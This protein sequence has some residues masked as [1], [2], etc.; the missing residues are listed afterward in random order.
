MLLRKLPDTSEYKRQS[1]RNGDY[2]EIET[3]WMETHNELARLHHAFRG[4]NT[5]KEDWVD[6]DPPRF[7]S[8]LERVDYWA[9]AE[10]EEHEATEAIDTFNAEIGYC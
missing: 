10:A 5:P 8:P 4:A 1:E 3:I 6:Y 7:L 2:T 9:D